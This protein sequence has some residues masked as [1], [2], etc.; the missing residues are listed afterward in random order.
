MINLNPL[1]L[2]NDNTGPYWLILGAMIPL[3][4]GAYW[5]ERSEI[6][7]ACR[8][9]GYCC[10]ENVTSFSRT[11]INGDGENDLTLKLNDGNSLKFIKNSGYSLEN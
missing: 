6:A 10:P 7:E 2:F 9:V 1:R 8:E 5:I 4:A 11:G 3:S